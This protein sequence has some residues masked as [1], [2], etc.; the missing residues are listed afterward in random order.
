MASSFLESKILVDKNKKRLLC[1]LNQVICMTAFD[2]FF[3][4]E[5]REKREK[6]LNISLKFCVPSSR[7]GTVHAPNKLCGEVDAPCVRL[8]RRG[9]RRTVF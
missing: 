1:I 9:N 6:N 3:N 4:R 8:V 7:Q 5:R 2:L